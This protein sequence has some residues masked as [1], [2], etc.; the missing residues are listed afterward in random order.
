MHPRDLPDP[1]AW[2]LP[3]FSFEP[4]PGGHRNVV[5]RG[6]GDGGSYV[7][8]RTRRTEAQ[9]AWLDH[10]R[11]PLAQAG[12][13]ACLPHPTEDGTFAHRGWIAERF[14]PGRPVGAEDQSTLQGAIA[15]LHQSTYGI[16]QRPGFA[17]ALDLLTQDLGGDIDLRAMPDDLVASC[18]AAWAAL[19]DEA[20]SVINADLN[21]S[22]LAVSSDGVLILYDWDEA[23]VDRGLFDQVALGT[24]DDPMAKRAAL[25]YEIASCWRLEPKRARTLAAKL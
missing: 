25:A 4:L 1:A 9:L 13:I 19:P 6:T 10:V 21:P 23:R 15:A 16:P 11:A 24:C 2:G 17:S 12:A 22:N 5:L 7:F 20:A 14:V 18:R 3:D 8:K